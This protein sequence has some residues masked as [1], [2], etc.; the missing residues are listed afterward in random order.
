MPHNY[1]FDDE[2]GDFKVVLR[3]HI[4]YRYEVL[5]FLGKGSFG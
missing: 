3:D 2:R 1:G 4:G 5:D